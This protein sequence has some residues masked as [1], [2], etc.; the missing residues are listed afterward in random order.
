M[1]CMRLRRSTGMPLGRDDKEVSHSGACIG[2]PPPHQLEGAKPVW[3]LVW[4]MEDQKFCSSGHAFLKNLVSMW[5]SSLHLH[6]V[7]TCGNLLA[8]SFKT[9]TLR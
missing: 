2:E 7:C 9:V 5:K 8:Q 6:Q 4:C 3:N 1:G